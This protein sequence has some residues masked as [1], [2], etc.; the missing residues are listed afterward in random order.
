LRRKERREKE[1]VRRQ[2]GGDVDSKG[3]N[4]EKERLH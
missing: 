1:E 2:E 3:K 4:K